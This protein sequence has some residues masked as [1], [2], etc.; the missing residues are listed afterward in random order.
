MLHGSASWQ[1]YTERSFSPKRQSCLGHI[2]RKGIFSGS[3][4]FSCLISVQLEPVWPATMLTFQVRDWVKPVAEDYMST[5]AFPS[6]QFVPW[7]R[8]SL[9]TLIPA[10][11]REHLARSKEPSASV[12]SLV[13]EY[14][15]QKLPFMTSFPPEDGAA[16]SETEFVVQQ[17]RREQNSELQPRVQNSQPLSLVS[18]SSEGS[19]PAPPQQA[20]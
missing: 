6:H 17:P 13:I 19:E 4:R 20:I 12:K 3:G 11:F 8:T 14:K 2:L 15:K 1:N 10:L 9:F 18:K 5:S 7:R 16:R